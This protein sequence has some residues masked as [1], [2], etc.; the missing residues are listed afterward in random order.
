MGLLNSVSFQRL[1]GGL[2]AATK[3][4]SVLANNIANADTPGFK[5]SDVSFESL[6]A[7]QENGLK[8]TLGAK[9]TDSRHF[10]FGYVS[11]VPSAVVSTDASISMNNND[12]NVDMDREMALSAENQLRYNSYIE[13]LNSQITMMRTVVQGG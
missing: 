6:L 10:Q 2:A 7:G 11:A 3:R 9:I 8:P 12:N 13:Q 4:Q 1:Q 5:R